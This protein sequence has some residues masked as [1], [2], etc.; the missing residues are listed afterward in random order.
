LFEIFTIDLYGDFE[1]TCVARSLFYDT[2]LSTLRV[3]EFGISIGQIS[4]EKL[5]IA[6]TFGGANLDII[7]HRDTP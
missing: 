1:E 6:P 3:E 5:T 7:L 4:Y 2:V